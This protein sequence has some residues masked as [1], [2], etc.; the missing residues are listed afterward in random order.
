VALQGGIYK[1]VIGE[2]VGRSRQRCE[3]CCVRGARLLEVDRKCE[4]G[5]ASGLSEGTMIPVR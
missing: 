1:V 4:K 2:R 3:R 5:Q